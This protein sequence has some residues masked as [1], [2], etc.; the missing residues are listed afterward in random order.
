MRLGDREQLD[1][2]FGLGA[3]PN[4]EHLP[5]TGEVELLDSLEQGD[6]DLHWALTAACSTGV[7][8]ALA[9]TRS[10]IVGSRGR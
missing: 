4:G 9:G 10:S 7:R 5:R 2:V 6:R 1:L 8:S 3:R